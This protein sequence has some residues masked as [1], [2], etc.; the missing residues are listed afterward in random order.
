M[1]HSQ[2][3]LRGP[4]HLTESIIC[5]KIGCWVSDILRVPFTCCS[6]LELPGERTSALQWQVLGRSKSSFGFFR[7]MVWTNPERSFLANSVFPQ[8][9]LLAKEEHGKSFV[10]SFKRLKKLVSGS[11][12]LRREYSWKGI[13]GQAWDQRLLSVQFASLFVLKTLRNHKAHNCHRTQS[14][15]VKV[16]HSPCREEQTK[17]QRPQ[18]RKTPC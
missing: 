8:S 10:F 2:S 5:R 13:C 7:T 14:L 12:S 11:V 18:P 6:E 1:G 17:P 9:T 4:A 15:I 16:T 3:V